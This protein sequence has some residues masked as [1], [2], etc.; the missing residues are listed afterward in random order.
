MDSLFEDVTPRSDQAL[1]LNTQ[2]N[3]EY[4]VGRVLRQSGNGFTYLAQDPD[5]QVVVIQELF[6]KHLVSRNLGETE[7]RPMTTQAVF[8]LAGGIEMMLHEGDALRQMSHPNVAKV[9]EAFA[10]NS[11]AY[12]VS[13][14]YEGFTLSDLIMKHG[15]RL[16]ERMALEN[17][18]LALTGLKAIHD[19]KVVH[20]GIKPEQI[21]MPAAG[22]MILVNDGLYD[23]VLPHP[24]A[25]TG[26][27]AP[28]LFH[29]G[30]EQGPW[31]DLYSF[32]GVLYTALTGQQPAPASERIPV[33]NLTPPRA[34]NPDIS[35]ALEM[36]I[37]KLLSPEPNDRFASVGEFAKVL[38]PIYKAVIQ[39]QIPPKPTFLGVS[40]PVVLLPFPQPKPSGTADTQ[41]A[42]PAFREDWKDMGQK[43]LPA[44]DAPMPPFIQTAQ[45]I[46]AFT[47]PPPTDWDDAP[48]PKTSGNWEQPSATWST[49]THNTPQP[50]STDW[51]AEKASSSL[52]SEDLGGRLFPVDT[53][54]AKPIPEPTPLPITVSK[55]KKNLLPIFLILLLGIG[56][57]T[58]GGWWYLNHNNKTQVQFSTNPIR[59]AKLNIRSVETGEIFSTQ[60]PTNLML[61]PGKYQVSAFK[62]GFEDLNWLLVVNEG[63]GNTP[64]KVTLEM[65]PI[66]PNEI[67]IQVNSNPTGASITLDGTDTGV[68]TPAQLTVSARTHTLIYT[69][70]GYEA[71]TREFDAQT[72]RLLSDTLVKT[73]KPTVIVPPATK[74]S[75]T[76]TSKVVPTPPKNNTTSRL[77]PNTSPATKPTPTK[78]P[79]QAAKPVQQKPTASPTPAPTTQPAPQPTQTEQPKPKKSVIERLRDRIR[80]NKSDGSQPKPDGN[81]SP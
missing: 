58:A 71:L 70:S 27:D 75:A 68:V 14:Y 44:L 13:A 12:V 17:A 47:E 15:G 19:K 16:S 10:S 31:T 11:T 3:G 2:L 24:Y 9:F 22:K 46:P 25:S 6:P 81:Q 26:Y 73:K 79:V 8:D 36:V 42:M 56:G 50:S 64:Q 43:P 57:V 38:Q 41:A 69:L 59:G 28:E 21:Y 45:Q 34:L 61:T 30:M 18:L 67:T 48:A 53:V 40:S 1:P 65:T 63:Q 32:G 52:T 62:D 39:G 78:T 54:E 37:I 74:P 60:S 23:P 51:K 76:T 20:K 80:G 66:L 72:T 49:P 55:K 5:N 33:D 29:K 7:I 4:K 35:E 77:K